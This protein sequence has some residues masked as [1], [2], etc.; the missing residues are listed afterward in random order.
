MALDE[1]LATKGGIQKDRIDNI[2]ISYYRIILH[3]TI[4][5]FNPFCV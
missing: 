2:T 1:L 5:N 4:L 3:N